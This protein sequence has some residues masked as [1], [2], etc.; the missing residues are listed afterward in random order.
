MEASSSTGLGGMGPAGTQ[1]RFSKPESCTIPS[2]TMPASRLE[3]PVPFLLMSLGSI[4]WTR[5]LRRSVSTSNTRSPEPAKA[6][7]RLTA[8]VVLPSAGD[9]L[10][11][12]KLRARLSVPDS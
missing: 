1:A 2:F 6:R 12:R 10:L 7:A 5:G 3:R 4:L 8:Q 11:T 9:E